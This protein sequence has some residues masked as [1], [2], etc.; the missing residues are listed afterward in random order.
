MSTQRRTRHGALPASARLDSAY[1]SR[2]RPR[3]STTPAPPAHP[4]TVAPLPTPPVVRGWRPESGERALFIGGFAQRLEGPRVAA[5]HG[6]LHILILQ[7]YVT[8]PEST[9]RWSWAP[10]DL[11]LF[12]NRVTRHHAADDHG[13]RPR[14]PHRVTVVGDVPIGG[15]RSPGGVVEGEPTEHHTPSAA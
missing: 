11:A 12:D 3:S 13:D 1:R 8:R 7:T 14:R 4:T 15:D 5:S 10:G 2:V 6:L 9:A